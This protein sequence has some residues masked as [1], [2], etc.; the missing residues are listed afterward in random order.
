MAFHYQN[1]IKAKDFKYE[2]VN[3]KYKEIKKYA[4]YRLESM[5]RRKRN[6]QMRDILEL[7]KTSVA[8][9]VRLDQNT[10]ISLEKREERI[11]LINNII[12]PDDEYFIKTLIEDYNVDIENIYKLKDSIESLNRKDKDF[13]D[14][15]MEGIVRYYIPSFDIIDSDLKL[16]NFNEFIIWKLMEIIYLNPFLLEVKKEIGK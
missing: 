3:E 9:K 15:T 13:L 14:G 12:F 10:V 7:V 4:Y 1:I 16:G 6:V 11:L 5:K 2:E 8:K